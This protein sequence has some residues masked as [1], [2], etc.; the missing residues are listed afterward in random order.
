MKKWFVRGVL[1][2][3]SVSTGAAVLASVSRLEDLFY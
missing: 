3:P 1:G 2:S